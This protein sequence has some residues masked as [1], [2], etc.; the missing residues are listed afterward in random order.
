M[1]KKALLS[2]FVVVLLL[3]GAAF[4]L[5]NPSREGKIQLLKLKGTKLQSIW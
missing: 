5:F 4:I 2:I 1:N 3:A